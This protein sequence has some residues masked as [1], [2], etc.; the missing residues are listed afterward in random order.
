MHELCNKY[1]FESCHI[2]KN[3]SLL[4]AINLLRAILTVRDSQKYP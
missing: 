3:I 4:N 2:I 1:L